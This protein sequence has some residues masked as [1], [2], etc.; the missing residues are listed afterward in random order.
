MLL[1]C[2]RRSNCLKVKAVFCLFSDVSVWHPRDP[3]QSSW[4]RPCSLSSVYLTCLVLL[5]LQCSCGATRAWSLWTLSSPWGGRW[6]SYGRSWSW[7][8]SWETW[9]AQA[10]RQYSR[11]YR[12]YCKSADD[13]PS[14]QHQLSISVQH[15][16]FSV[17]RLWALSLA[18]P[19]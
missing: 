5:L 3:L 8:S 6:S 14:C 16:L 4:W 2:Q 10:A 19:G 15:T 11:F 9:G 13:A 12:F 17:C 1:K 18:A 7:W